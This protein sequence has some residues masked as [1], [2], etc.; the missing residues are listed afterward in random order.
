MSGKEGSRGIYETWFKCRQDAVVAGWR[1]GGDFIGKTPF[2]KKEMIK[3]VSLV[4]SVLLESI[5]QE[6]CGPF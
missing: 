4:S 2:L 6:A 3:V 5:K 1:E